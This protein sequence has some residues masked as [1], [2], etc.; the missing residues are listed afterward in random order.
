MHMHVACTCNARVCA[1]WC[2]VT[3]NAMAHICAGE[4]ARCNF[5]TPVFAIRATYATLVTVVLVTRAP[6]R[7]AASRCVHTPLGVVRAV[8]VRACVHACS[9]TRTTRCVSVI[10]L[11]SPFPCRK[12]AHTRLTF[13][14]VCVWNVCIWALL[15]DALLVR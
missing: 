8:C 14:C 6:L 4:D 9:R 15:L 10:I 2:K 7:S 5:A 11:V 13:N 3:L 1:C 12:C